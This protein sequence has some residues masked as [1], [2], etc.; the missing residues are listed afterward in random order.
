[1]CKPL[2]VH[3]SPQLVHLHHK[4]TN[5]MDLHLINNTEGCHD[6][7]QPC[8]INAET[9]PENIPLPFLHPSNFHANWMYHQ[10]ITQ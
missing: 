9:I 3:T 1:M 8:Q 4:A 7:P 2:N 6:F 10:I 5:L